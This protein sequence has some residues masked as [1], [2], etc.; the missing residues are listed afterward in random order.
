[1]DAPIVNFFAFQSGRYAVKKDVWLRDEG[2][3][4]VAIEVYYQPGH[5]FN[6]DAMVAAA[7]ASLSYNSKHFGAYQYRQ[8][9]II[10]F[11]ATRPSR[12][13]SRTRCRT[14]R[15]LAL[16]RA[17]GRMTRRTSTTPTT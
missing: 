3:A 5:E 9:R 14:P 12:R 1:M 8:F 17:C 13:P 10:E 15:A 4:P 6:L 2:G 11:R 7:K 16:L